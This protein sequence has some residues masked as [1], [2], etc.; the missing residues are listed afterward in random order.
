MAATKEELAARIAAVKAR[1]RPGNGQV[2][3]MRIAC[4]APSRTPTPTPTPTAV[5]PTTEE[6]PPPE[7]VP[8]TLIRKVLANRERPTEDAKTH[9]VRS[10]LK[11]MTPRPP[12]PDPAPR[13]LRVTRAATEDDVAPPAP[14]SVIDRIQ[15]MRGA[16]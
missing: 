7:P 4:A 10:L 9:Y 11:A 8:S 14:P 13:Q 5:A 6:A 3:Q 2:P 12:E 15:K 1:T 16:K